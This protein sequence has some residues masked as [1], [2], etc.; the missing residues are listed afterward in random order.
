MVGAYPAKAHSGPKIQMKGFFERD[1]NH[2]SHREAARRHKGALI[3]AVK[4][5]SLAVNRHL[6]VQAIP[7]GGEAKAGVEPEV[8]SVGETDLEGN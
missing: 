2:R 7:S 1:L 8:Y 6:P 3:N 4:L 5:H